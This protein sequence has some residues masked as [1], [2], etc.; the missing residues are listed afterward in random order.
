MITLPFGL[1]IASTN[2]AMIQPR[3]GEGSPKPA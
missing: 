2:E 1:G 3:A